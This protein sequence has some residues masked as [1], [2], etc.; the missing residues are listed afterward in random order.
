MPGAAR[1]APIQHGVRKRREITGANRT[2]KTPE[3]ADR[4]MGLAAGVT[5]D[6]SEKLQV[7]APNQPFRSWRAMTM[8]WIWLVPS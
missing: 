8:R 6:W 7:S 5:R 3:R 1:A 4:L 2:I